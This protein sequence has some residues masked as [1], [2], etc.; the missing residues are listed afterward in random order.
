VTLPTIATEMR[1][2][3]GKPLIKKAL[4]PSVLLTLNI[5]CSST[6]VLRFHPVNR[7]RQFAL[8]AYCAVLAYCFAWI[9][10][11]VQVGYAR[12]RYERLGY[13]WLWEGP[14]PPQPAPPTGKFSIADID[15]PLQ[16]A[17]G[18]TVVSEEPRPDSLPKA[19]PTPSNPPISDPP[20]K[21]DPF[22]EP[23]LGLI[24]LRFLAATA[25]ATAAWFAIGNGSQSS[26]AHFPEAP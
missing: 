3:L 17:G 8:I 21:S 23:D 5:R 19:D 24:F 14:P 15:P 10:W 12:V 22:A 18:Y 9:P 6:T 20:P 4:L 7:H 11:R 2:I 25:M 1:F 26:K 16:S 13:G